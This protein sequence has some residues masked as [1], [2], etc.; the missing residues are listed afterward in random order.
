MITTTTPGHVTTSS[1]QQFQRRAFAVTAAAFAALVLWSVEVPLLGVSLSVRTTP[2]S[3]TQK[4][5]VGLVIA[6]S[7]LA[8]LLGWGLLAALEHLTQWAGTIWTAA[9]GVV[10]VL[11][12]TGPLTTAVTTGGK[13][14]LVA[15]HLSVAAVLIPLLRRSAPPR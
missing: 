6:V 1:H 13:A 4:I 15:L 12:L 3:N 11:S 2:G 8:S 5:G 7:V 10:L 9:A 14:S